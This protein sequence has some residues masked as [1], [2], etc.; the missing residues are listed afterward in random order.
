MTTIYHMATDELGK[1]ICKL[2][3]LDYT[4]VS[5]IDIHIRPSEPVIIEIS[6][7]ISLDDSE[8]LEKI[9]LIY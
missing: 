8:K 1:A 4:I 5:A 9:L 2:L 3:D 7:V 6:R